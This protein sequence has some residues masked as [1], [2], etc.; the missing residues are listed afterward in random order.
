M[1]PAEVEGTGSF[2]WADVLYFSDEQIS[3]SNLGLLF[4]FLNTTEMFYER[5][6]LLHCIAHCYNNL[7]NMKTT[8]QA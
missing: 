2:S 8:I 4:H 3:C 1:F 5:N 6:Y 7:Q